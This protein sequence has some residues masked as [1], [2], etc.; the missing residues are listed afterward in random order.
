[1][2]LA[3]S[4]ALASEKLSTLRV[5][6]LTLKSKVL[7]AASNVQPTAIPSPISHSRRGLFSLMPAFYQT[8]RRNLLWVV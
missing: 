8:N 1:M 5:P 6:S 3:I 7:V 4:A 2:S